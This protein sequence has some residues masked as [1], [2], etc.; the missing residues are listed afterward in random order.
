MKILIKK[1]IYLILS[2]LHFLFKVSNIIELILLIKDPFK[3]EV[4]CQN[5]NPVFQLNYS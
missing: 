1:Y 3:S 4:Y 5:I 2:Y